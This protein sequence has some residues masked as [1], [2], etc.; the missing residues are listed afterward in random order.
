[1]TATFWKNLIMATKWRSLDSLDLNTELEIMHLCEVGS[2][3][4]SKTGR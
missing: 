3:S 2:L 4:K 1:M